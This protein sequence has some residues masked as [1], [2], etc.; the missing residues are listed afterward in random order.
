MKSVR[1][2]KINTVRYHLHMESKTWHKTETDSQAERTD[3]RL[4][5]GREERRGNGMDRELGVS[6]CKPLH[7][8]WISHDVPL[9]STGNYVQSPETDHDGK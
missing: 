4:P 9:Y 5:R 2:R 7:L 6:R 1:K 3:L 8:E